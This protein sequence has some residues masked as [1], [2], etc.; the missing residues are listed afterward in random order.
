MSP[1][2][3][4][5]SFHAPSV[6]T[7]LAASR[8]ESRA[9]HTT[10]GRLP[11]HSSPQLGCRS[12]RQPGM[13]RL[14]SQTV[15]T[16]ILPPELVERCLEFLP[17]EEVHTNVKQVSKEVRSAARRSL[18]RGRWRPVKYILENAIVTN[19]LERPPS[20]AETAR[21][22]EA[23]ALDPGLVLLELNLLWRNKKEGHEDDIDPGNFWAWNRQQF[24]PSVA[25]FLAL[26]EPSIDGLGRLTMALERIEHRLETREGGRY[27]TEMPN[28]LLA[29][30]MERLGELGLLTRVITEG[31]DW[32]IALDELLNPE[33]LVGSGLESWTELTHM[34][35]FIFWLRKWPRDELHMMMDVA[36][37]LSRNW[38]DRR[39]ADAMVS[40][41]DDFVQE[42]AN[43]LDH[44]D[45]D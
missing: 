25:R 26:V 36:R 17:F 30:W 38:Q 20:A 27:R 34:A 29:L 13:P 43:D 31:D 33:S 6:F 1:E 39:K 28:T 40:G 23:W 8:N 22:R 45:P 18:T 4:E 11:R 5:T 19:A 44:D 32:E 24:K 12:L 7:P 16:G 2:L 42:L 41:V 9:P 15:F 14:R 10:C 21:F 3:Y 37:A 35:S